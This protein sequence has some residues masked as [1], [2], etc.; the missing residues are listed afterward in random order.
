MSLSWNTHN[1]SI[2]KLVTCNLLATC[3]TLYGPLPHKQYNDTKIYLLIPLTGGCQLQVSYYV[4]P[5]ILEYLTEYSIQNNSNFRII[6]DEA[7]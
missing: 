5:N 4:H 2:I 3:L 7:C 1:T 6:Q